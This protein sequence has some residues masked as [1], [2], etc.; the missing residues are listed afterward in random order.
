MRIGLL[1]CDH[2]RERYLLHRR[3]LRRHVR[4]DGGRAP[5]PT[6]RSCATTPGTASSRR[7]PTSATGG[8][9]TGSSASVYDDE[10]WIERAGRTS[11]ATST[12]PSVPASASASATSCWPTRSGGRTERAAAAG[13]SARCRWSVVGHRAVDG[14][15]RCRPP[16]SSTATRTRST[17]LPAG[18]RVLGSAAALPDR[19]AGGRRR[20]ASGCR[21]TPSSA[22]ATCGRCSRTASTGSA[23][24]A[25]A[26]ALAIAARAHRRRRRWPGG[27]WRSCGRHEGRTAEERRLGRHAMVTFGCALTDRASAR[28]SR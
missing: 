18:G 22:R 11:C 28:G 24:R 9:C 19:H 10:P 27:S 2:V 6:P 15:R 26:A 23:R 17:A 4:G 21:P 1:E 12:T 3:R 8:S 25:T 7:G 13:A 20:P 16:R 5:I 14:A